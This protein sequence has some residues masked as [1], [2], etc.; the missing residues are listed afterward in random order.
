MLTFIKNI[1]LFALIYLFIFIGCKNNPEKSND[2]SYPAPKIDTLTYNYVKWYSEREDI[3]Y[4]K[5][6]KIENDSFNDLTDTLLIF[7]S[8]MEI[9]FKL[10]SL[11]EFDTLSKDEK[12]THITLKI[13]RLRLNEGLDY[14]RNYINNYSF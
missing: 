14:L 10:D 8:I 3:V 12:R 11:A 4:M 7:N 5:V 9:N 2:I 13:D 1:L 6:F